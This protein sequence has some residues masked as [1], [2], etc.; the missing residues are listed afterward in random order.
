MVSMG[1][2]IMQVLA[3]TYGQEGIIERL[4]DTH[5]FQSLSNVLG[6]DW[7]SSGTTTVLCGVL[8]RV[9]D[10][11]EVGVKMAGGKGIKSRQTQQQLTAIGD[12]LSLGEKKTEELKYSSRITAKVDNTAIQAGYQLYH[13]CMFVTEKGKWTVVQ[14]GMNPEN[15]MARRYH[16]LE[17]QVK[18]YTEEPHQAIVG[19]VIH[20]RVLNLTSFDSNECK[21]TMLDQ[22]REKPEKT[23]RIFETLTTHQTTL[24]DTQRKPEYVIPRRMDWN[25]VE[26]A[27][28]LQPEKF[29]NLLA[30]EGMGPATVRGLTLI[31]ELVYG[32][33]PS[34][35]DP[36]KYSFAFG[37]KDGVPYPVNRQSYDKA[38]NTLK[39][40]VEQAK[41]GQT[42]KIEAI[43]RLN[44]G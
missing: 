11:T 13:H 26:R 10:E 17:T 4:A 5:F 29:E 22:A 23:R 8:E 38:I 39:E 25:A 2:N 7:N 3:D 18:E 15:K 30:I 31:S 24:N 43:K 16:W 40:A 35:K 36:V 33:Q 44:R 19:D 27:Y 28:Q 42:E 37:G 14:Q 21:K 6:F 1:K 34:W 32:S 20:E 12:E 9:F 41:L